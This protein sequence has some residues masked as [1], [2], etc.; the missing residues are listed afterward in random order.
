MPPL[1]WTPLPPLSLSCLKC[2][3]D[4]RDSKIV[5]LAKKCR[6]LTVALNKERAVTRTSQEKILQLQDEITRLNKE[7]ELIASP[8]ARAAAL[9]ER[10]IRSADTTDANRDFKKELTQQ[11]KLV[12]S[13]R[14]PSLCRITVSPLSFSLLGSRR[15]RSERS[16][17]NLKR[18]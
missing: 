12:S 6:N 9:R 1:P 3:K 5:S 7:I 18:R 16:I 10:D 15:K 8:A 2:P 13:P 14:H 11:Q 4:Y 17:S